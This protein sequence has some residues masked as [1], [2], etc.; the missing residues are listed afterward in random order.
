MSFTCTMEG[1][2]KES[3]G[4]RWRLWVPAI[5]QENHIFLKLSKLRKKWS[6]F[7]IPISNLS[8]RSL[9][10]V[11]TEIL[12]FN[13]TSQLNGMVIQCAAV[14]TR[15]LNSLK[16]VYSPFAIARLT[17]DSEVVSGDKDTSV[18][19][20]ENTTSVSVAEDYSPENTTSASDYSVPCSENTTSASETD[21]SSSNSFSH[22]NLSWIIVLLT[23]FQSSH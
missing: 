14:D 8:E 13:A 10:S 1:D 11:R 5:E 2:L 19:H 17:F 3:L 7:N 15:D 9:D 16:F 18:P 23:L 22:T 4:I 6:K 21:T 12:I 20:P